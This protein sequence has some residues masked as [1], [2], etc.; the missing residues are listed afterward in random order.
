MT[1]VTSTT[2]TY[3][4]VVLRE[5]VRIALTLA[6]LND[7]EV[8]TADIENDYLTAPI[9]EK[10]WCKLGPEFGD[11]AGKRAIIVR[12]LY[13]LKSAG[14]SFRN[15]LA[16]CMRHLGWES[17][18]ADQDLW[19]KPEV[20][21]EDNFQYYAYCL[22]YVDDILMVHHAGVKALK[23]IDHFFKTKDGSIGD[24]EFYF[25]S[26]IRPITLPNGV[27]AWGM[28][29]SKYIQAAVAIVKSY[30]ERE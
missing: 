26:K 29:A 20:R 8:K 25:G 2:V 9:G 16:D 30:Y 5:S 23:E 17:C 4:S 3:A 12:A 7:L 11:D 10:I 28:S 24:P 18:K 14:A 22:L 1:E 19:F 21:K 27:T 6:A 15:H 13:G